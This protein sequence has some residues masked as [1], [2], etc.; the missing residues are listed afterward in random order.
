MLT[1]R[2]TAILDFEGQ[3]WT[4]GGAKDA[5][6]RDQF[7][8]SPTRYYAELGA[9]LNNPDALAYAPSTVRRVVRLQEKR[10]A[11]RTSG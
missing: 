9:L 10:R 3:W 1:D 5:N 6:I 11:A 4:S 7:D 8:C 2:Q